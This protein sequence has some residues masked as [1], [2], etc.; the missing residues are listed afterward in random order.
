MILLTLTLIGNFG[1]FDINFLMTKGGP[2]NY[3]N[4]MAVRLYSMAF[5]HFR[6]GYAAAL[7]VVMLLI[8]S[9]IAFVYVR[10]VLT[11]NEEAE[12]WE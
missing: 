12:R 6:L 1:Y 9:V 3:T 11:R 5:Q 7:G 2:L 8:T 10:F 4:V